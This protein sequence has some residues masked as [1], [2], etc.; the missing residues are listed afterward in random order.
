MQKQIIYP[1]FISRLFAVTLDISI[2]SLLIIPVMNYVKD[3][4]F[5][6]VF[7]DFFS[8]QS[9]EMSGSDAIIWATRSPEFSEYISSSSSSII[10]FFGILF[11]INIF[12]MGV[13][14]IV[15]WYKFGTSPGKILMRMKIVDA[16]DLTKK[17]SLLNCF[18]RFFSYFLSP[19]GM[20]SIIFTKKG[21]ALHD[22]IANTV[23]IK[24]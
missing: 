14:F 23:V 24:A 5:L 1:D 3:G 7:R 2:I 6:Y 12:S 4:I 22:K 21:I 9:I 19:V 17:P 8:T 13:Y 20:W 18:K 15:F 16:D 10:T 11:F